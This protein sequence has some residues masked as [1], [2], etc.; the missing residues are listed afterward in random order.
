LTIS[1][2][3]TFKEHLKDDGDILGHLIVAWTK[4]YLSVKII[5]Q[6]SKLH[7]P[8]RVIATNVRWKARTVVTLYYE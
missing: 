1:L 7:Y 6:Q 4:E 3:Y 5:N 8:T 2:I